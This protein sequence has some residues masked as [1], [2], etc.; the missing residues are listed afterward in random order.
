VPKLYPWYNLIAFTDA[1][2]VPLPTNRPAAVLGRQ[3]GGLVFASGQGPRGNAD[4]VMA[5]RYGGAQPN[6]G[7][8][9]EKVWC[10]LHPLL[11]RR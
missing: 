1:H 7:P 9:L 11:V 4:D 6:L 3:A 2:G 5:T 8:G 10:V